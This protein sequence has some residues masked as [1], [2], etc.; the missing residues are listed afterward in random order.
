MALSLNE[1]SFQLVSSIARLIEASGVDDISIKYSFTQNSDNN[2]WPSSDCK[3]FVLDEVSLQSKGIL[4]FL[5]S[6]LFSGSLNG[7]QRL[8]Q[9]RAFGW[10]PVSKWRNVQP[11]NISSTLNEAGGG[12]GAGFQVYCQLDFQEIEIASAGGGGGGGRRLSL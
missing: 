2:G 7:L 1:S 12:S 8:N 4:S 11:N 3:D 9:T 6:D 10:L 5:V